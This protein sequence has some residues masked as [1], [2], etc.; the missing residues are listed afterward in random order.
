MEATM[1]CISRH[2]LS[3]T[4]MAH[5]TNEAGLSTGIVNLH[6]GSKDTLLLATLKYV[7]E[8]YA[9]GWMAIA[10][11]LQLSPAERV[12]RL[13]AFDFSAKITRRDKLAVWFA[14]WGEAKSRPLYQKICASNDDLCASA[15]AKLITEMGVVQGNGPET[16]AQAIASTYAALVDGLWLDMLLTPRQVPR[17]VAEQRA[18]N[19]LRGQ[20]PAYGECLNE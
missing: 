14:F 7:T 2:G 17:Q 16:D 5:I 8:E 20:L 12:R 10:E 15:L 3:A 4:T 13:V 6:F 18:L 9:A 1:R 11:N 19:F